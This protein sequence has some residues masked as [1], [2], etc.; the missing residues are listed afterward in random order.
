MAKKYGSLCEAYPKRKLV[1]KEK[2]K[3]QCGEAGKALPLH[4]IVFT[5][6]VLGP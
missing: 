5:Q 6:P 3:K 4:S 1:H 2:K